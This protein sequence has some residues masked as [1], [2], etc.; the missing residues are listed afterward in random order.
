MTVGIGS[1][2]GSERMG[3]ECNPTCDGVKK[4]T[5]L[6]LRPLSDR[7]GKLEELRSEL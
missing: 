2:S 4:Q 7:D 5:Q 1:V 3:R 6:H